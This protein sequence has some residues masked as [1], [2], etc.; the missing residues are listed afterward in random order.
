MMQ[1]IKAR[2]IQRM[3]QVIKDG[4]REICSCH[5]TNRSDLWKESG[6]SSRFNC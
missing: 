4:Y 2:N 6:I 5:A 1:I 3:E